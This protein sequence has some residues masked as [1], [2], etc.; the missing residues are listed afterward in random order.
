MSLLALYN[1]MQ[2]TASTDHEPDEWDRAAAEA[3]MD[4]DTYMDKVAEQRAYEEASLVKVAEESRVLGSAMANGYF[5]ALTKY[6]NASPVSDGVPEIFIKLAT[7]SKK[8]L[9]TNLVA[10]ATKQ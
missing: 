4:T 2:K 1:G 10:A 5:D 9:V 7:A 6:A 8:A 3:G